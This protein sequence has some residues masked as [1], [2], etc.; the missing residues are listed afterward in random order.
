M[1]GSRGLFKS[2]FNGILN[3]V[4]IVS[5]WVGYDR[6][7]GNLKVVC[8]LWCK[9]RFLGF[10]VEWEDSKCIFRSEVIIVLI[11]WYCWFSKVIFLG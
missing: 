11:Y 3:V 1:L 7:K 8:F 10:V 2:G 9:E 5:L 4:F 6:Y